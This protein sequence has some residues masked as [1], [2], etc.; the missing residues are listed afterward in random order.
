MCESTFKKTLEQH[1]ANW[2]SA[3]RVADVVV[4]QRLTCH[5]EHQLSL[6]VRLRRL[7]GREQQF[8]DCADLG[9]LFM[10]MSQ[11]KSFSKVPE[12][13]VDGCS[14]V[15]TG[16]TE[17]LATD[18]KPQM[19]MTNPSQQEGVSSGLRLPEIA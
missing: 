1:S 12:I 17:L 15:S 11:A 5:R 13:A 14:D 7:S 3:L 2:L 9:G 6:L 10:Q 4:L 18:L 19:S 8:P 16:Q